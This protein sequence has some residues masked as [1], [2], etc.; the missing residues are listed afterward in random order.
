MSVQLHWRPP[1]RNS[2]HVHYCSP[3]NYSPIDIE[4][5]LGELAYAIDVAPLQW[6]HHSHTTIFLSLQLQSKS[7][8]KNHPAHFDQHSLGHGKVHGVGQAT[9]GAQDMFAEQWGT[10]GRV[11]V[12]K[13]GWI[14]GRKCKHELCM[15]GLMHRKLR[16]QHQDITL[17]WCKVIG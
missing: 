2:D 15:P 13:R 16:P 8:P 4:C 10:R 1:K 14:C 5:Y 6:L 3:Y 11:R 12:V 7:L 17:S 9:E